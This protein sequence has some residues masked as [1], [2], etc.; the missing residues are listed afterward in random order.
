MSPADE[1]LL[2]Y[3]CVTRFYVLYLNSVASLQP[4]V[5]KPPHKAEY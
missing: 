3:S 1:Y 5:A 4:A 2:N